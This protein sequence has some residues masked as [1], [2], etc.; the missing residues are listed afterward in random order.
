MPS[1]NQVLNVLSGKSQGRRNRATACTHSKIDDGH[2]LSMAEQ[3]TLRFA[4]LFLQFGERVDARVEVFPSEAWT[5]AEHT[6]S[7]AS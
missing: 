7:I 5:D 3:A 4:R 2:L 1:G 6:T